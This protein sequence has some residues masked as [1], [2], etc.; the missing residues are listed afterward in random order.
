M[1]KIEKKNTYAHREREKFRRFKK[2][3]KQK[4]SARRRKRQ[5]ERHTGRQERFMQ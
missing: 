1:R 4:K 5:A 2:I 3:D